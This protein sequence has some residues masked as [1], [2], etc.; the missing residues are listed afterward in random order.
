MSEI[1]SKYPNGEFVGID[2][3]MKRKNSHRAGLKN[4]D[5]TLSGVSA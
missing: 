5:R 3:A 1:I 4:L 2:R